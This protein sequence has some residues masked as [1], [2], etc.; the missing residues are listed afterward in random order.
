MSKIYKEPS[1][2]FL[3]HIFFLPK[4]KKLKLN[5]KKRTGIIGVPDNRSTPPF[6]SSLRHRHQH[7]HQ[8][9]SFY[10][11]IPSLHR[12]DTSVSASLST[13][14][15]SYGTSSLEPNYLKK[16]SGSISASFS[17]PKSPFVHYGAG[18]SGRGVRVSGGAAAL[19]GASGRRPSSGGKPQVELSFAAQMKLLIKGA[20]EAPKYMNILL[21]AA[22]LSF[23][24]VQWDWG[25]GFV[26]TTA[27][28]AL[29]PLAAILGDLTDDLA[30]S[31]G[32]T[33]GAFLNVTFGNATEVIIC[34]VAIQHNLFSIIKASMLGSILGNML[35][36]LGSAFIIAGTGFT[37]NRTGV[38]I[39]SSLLLMSCFALIIPTA[40]A[41]LPSVVQG[42]RTVPFYL[43]AGNEHIVLKVSRYLSLICC[44]CY[45]VFVYYQS[46]NRHHFEDVGSDEELGKMERS[47]LIGGDE[48]SGE[49]E[50]EEEEPQF[51][52][53]FAI[54]ALAGVTILVSIESEFVVQTL[55]PFAVTSG[56][57]QP[58]IAVILLPIVGNV[59]EHASAIMMASRGKIDVAIGVA[60]GSS[61]QIAVFVIPVLVLISWALNGENPDALNSG[62]GA[63][64]LNFHPFQTVLLLV[65]VLVVNAVINVEMGTWITGL[66]LLLTYTVCPLYNGEGKGVGRNGHSF[67]AAS[68]SN[69]AHYRRFVHGHCG[70]C[71]QP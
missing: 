36:V 38:S 49:D 42:G 21:F 48:A 65:S 30:C 17:I 43:G 34:V 41:H 60:V 8:H 14:K 51:S 20:D 54:A 53:S 6:I 63:L 16:R 56:I 29:V 4:V 58:F 64:D 44:A 33:W 39:Y 26:F 1:L 12:K 24:A 37:F 3:K 71:G 67:Y 32:D 5:S 27:F 35:L 15:M 57:S 47:H 70:I 23:P 7:Q 66:F 9:P 40:L 59:C 25:P 31:L 22:L 62:P 45:F 55:E 2:K 19:L 61:I 13:Q 68:N 11:N 50:E 28:I 10:S 18:N 46:A 69:S 52:P